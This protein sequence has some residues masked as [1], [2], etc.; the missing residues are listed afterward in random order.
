[1]H[2]IFEVAPCPA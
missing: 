1:M 2:D